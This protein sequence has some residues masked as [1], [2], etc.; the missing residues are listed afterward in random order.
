MIATEH[1]PAGPDLAGHAAPMWWRTSSFGDTQATSVHELS[2]LGEH[3][4]AC[5]LGGGRLFTVGSG[6]RA[7]HRYVVSRFITTLALALL[8]IGLGM[9][10]A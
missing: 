2:A 6:A 10:A 5:R 3:L 9:L 8:V 7:M 1:D 4:Q